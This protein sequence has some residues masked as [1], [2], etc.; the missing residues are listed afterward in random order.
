MPLFLG[1]QK[2]KPWYL[3]LVVVSC[4]SLASK[5]KN[6]TLPLLEMQVNLQI[7]VISI[8]LIEK[9]ISNHAIVT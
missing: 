3:R 8:I 9:T 6:T 2:G 4:L 1:L 7:H 5:M